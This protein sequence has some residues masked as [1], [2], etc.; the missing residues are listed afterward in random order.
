MQKPVS[1]I[2]AYDLLHEPQ[3]TNLASATRA[4]LL[5]LPE[6]FSDLDLFTM[7]AG[8]SYRGD[9]RM[10]YF[11]EHPRK[12]QN[13]V[14]TN[15][16]HFHR[17]YAP[18][19][20]AAVPSLTATGADRTRFAQDAS[21]AV[22]A[23]LL[24]QLPL[25]VRDRLKMT[26]SLSNL[27]ARAMG[28]GG[29]GGAAA[30][31][32]PPSA[33]GEAEAAVR[34]AWERLPANKTAKMVKRAIHQVVARSSRTQGLKGIFTAGVWKAFVYGMKKIDKYRQGMG[35]VGSAAGYSR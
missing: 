25:A 15:L 4:A 33:V 11:G 22:R 29:G 31:A 1:I 5:L 14:T 16:A 23:G 12:V 3:Q 21:P 20:L 17:L 35:K 24:G 7:I 26:R 28:G 30:A 2:K 10:S 9:F 13:I 18:H 32:A 19:V 8:L 34:A 27:A 6:S